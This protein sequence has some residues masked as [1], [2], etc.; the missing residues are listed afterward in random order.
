MDLG[1]KFTAKDT[2]SAAWN[3][4]RLDSKTGVHTGKGKN[5]PTWWQVDMQGDDY[6]TVS[7]MVLA[8]RGDGHGI[9]RYITAV[10]FE[11][12]YDHGQTWSLHENGKWFNTGALREDGANQ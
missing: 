1:A 9:D 11:V 6:Y 10:Q 4:P 12:S 8:K 3:N 2:W 7:S 5:H